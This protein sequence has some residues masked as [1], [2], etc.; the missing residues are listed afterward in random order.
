MWATNHLAPKRELSSGNKI[1]LPRELQKCR[2]WEG[3]KSFDIR[4]KYCQGIILRWEHEKGKQEYVVM[5]VTPASTATSLSNK[6]RPG[7]S[8]CFRKIALEV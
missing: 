4:R 6:T 5:Q 1:C 7:V 8:L 2:R 3:K